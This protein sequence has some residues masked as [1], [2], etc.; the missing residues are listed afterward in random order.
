MSL[1]SVNLVT[2]ATQPDRR[3]ENL[4]STSGAARA[5]ARANHIHAS[6]VWNEPLQLHKIERNGL[7]AVGILQSITGASE[8]F[9]QITETVVLLC[10]SVRSQFHDK[11]WMISGECGM[12]TLQNGQFRSIHVNFYEIDA[13]DVA[14]PNE[15]IQ[16]CYGCFTCGD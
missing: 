13:L 6:P 1:A 11:L 14:L 7:A 5:S 15:I 10:V 16:C 3:S 12:A 2:M 8:Q 4:V 9:N